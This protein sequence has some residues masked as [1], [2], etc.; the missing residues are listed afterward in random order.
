MHRHLGG[1]RAGDE[2]AGAIGGDSRLGGMV[3][4]FE[5]VNHFVGG[6][7]HDG[8]FRS[9]PF[10]DEESLLIRA[11]RHAVGKAGFAHIQHLLLV[12]LI[13]RDGSQLITQQTAPAAAG[14]LLA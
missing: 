7:I 14:G 11:E 6:D 12:V 10:A 5:C 3:A 2:E 4:C 8:H 13:E 1:V 9:A